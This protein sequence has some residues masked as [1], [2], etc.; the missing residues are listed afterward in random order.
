MFKCDKCGIC[1]RNLKLSPLY[2]DLDRGDGVCK[3]LQDSLCS[4][5]TSRPLICR[6]D[7]CYEF[8]KQSMTLEEYY[9]LN[10]ESCNKLKK[11]KE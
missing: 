1:C 6:V 2:V 3:Y 11:L 10:Y 4:I 5:Y 7:E 9:E 8:F